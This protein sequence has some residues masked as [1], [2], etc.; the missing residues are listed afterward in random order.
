MFQIKKPPFVI[1]NDIFFQK[2]FIDW[3]DL[4]ISQVLFPNQWELK[5]KRLLRLWKNFD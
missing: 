5:E 1:P 3:P 4:E 2:I